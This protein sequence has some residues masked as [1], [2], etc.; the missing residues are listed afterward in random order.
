MFTL[1]YTIKGF[2]EKFLLR[3]S[4]SK[5]WAR[6]RYGWGWWSPEMRPH[7]ARALRMEDIHA[8]INVGTEWHRL[9]PQRAFKWGLDRATLLIAL[10]VWGWIK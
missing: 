1:G 9:D 10:A 6:A 5:D 8:W 3:H 2:V 7:W 4:H